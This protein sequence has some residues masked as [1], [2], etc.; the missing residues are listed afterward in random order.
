M[1]ITLFMVM[2]FS[3]WAAETASSVS[4]DQIQVLQISP[5]EGKAVIRMPDNRARV[6]QAGDSVGQ[7]AK[8]IEVVEGRIVIEEKGPQGIETVIIRVEGRKQRVERIRKAVKEGPA[9]YSPSQEAKP[10]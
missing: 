2:S 6:I 9:L 3:V 5:N 10:K 4:I 7:N 1:F 8:V